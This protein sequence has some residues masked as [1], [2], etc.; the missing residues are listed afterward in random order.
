MSVIRRKFFKLLETSFYSWVEGVENWVITV[1]LLM[2]SCF[3][4]AS[5]ISRARS[6][7]QVGL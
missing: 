7:T 4:F 1:S 3:Q 6:L 5:G 2:Y